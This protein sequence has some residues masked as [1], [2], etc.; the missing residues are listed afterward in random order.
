MY[1]AMCVDFSP[2]ANRCLTSLKHD[3][4]SRRSRAAVANRT[5][6]LVR[7]ID[8]KPAADQS[9]AVMQRAKIS[10][11]LCPLVNFAAGGPPVS[12]SAP[13][14]FLMM[15]LPRL[16]LVTRFLRMR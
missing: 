8:I 6:D 1:A 3:K 16:D 11:R 5:S 2:F 12:V 7:G 14:L 9:A 4:P 15:A 13:L 10:F